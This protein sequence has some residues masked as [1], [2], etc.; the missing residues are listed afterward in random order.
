MY[1]NGIS[2]VSGN[3]GTSASD[4]AQPLYIGSY[5][6]G[7]LD[8]LNG[9]LSN[10]RI[11]KGTAVYTSNFTPP[12]A[13]LT[14]ITN[15]SLLTCQSNR[16]VDNSTNNFA[17][18]RNGDVRVTP[19]SPF[20]PS[21]AYSPSVNG[22]SGYFDGSGDS[23]QLAS[24]INL[25]L[26]GD[27]T[28]ELWFY[29][30]SSANGRKFINRWSGGAQYYMI[31]A[32]ASNQIVF[33]FNTGSISITSSTAFTLNQWQHVAVS[34][35]GST[36][37]MYLNGISVG[38][39]TESGNNGSTSEPLFIGSYSNNAE[40]FHG[41]ISNV[42]IVKGTAVY[43][44]AFTPPTTPP[45]AITNTSLL[46]NFTNGG[47]TDAT[48]RNNLETMGNARLDTS[49]KK[50]GTS[51]ISL[52]NT[53]TGTSRL[54]AAHAPWLNFP[55]AFTFEA[56]VYP[57]NLSGTIHSILGK[58]GSWYWGV[59][60]GAYSGLVRLIGAG[61]SILA[62]SV[63]GAVVVNQWQHLAMT[64]DTSNNLR[65]FVN[66]T[67]SGSTNNSSDALTNVVNLSIGTYTPGESGYDWRGYID[68][69]RLTQ[70]IA[71]YTA[72]FTPPT[73]P[74]PQN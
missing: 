47:I 5:G 16:F 9:Y 25:A 65:I 8:Y 30:L 7:P 69:L 52:P 50:Y 38:T 57:T 31:E 35:S 53:T 64:R 29:A 72:N 60:G 73:A 58:Y 6:A 27:F 49:I 13:P 59:Y 66:G 40:N 61:G 43:T 67:Q 45:T 17:I 48:G 63:T 36:I 19:F 12:T 15:T 55:G 39:R 26:S 68:D 18:T 46:L 42:R 14:A 51:S 2:V 54:I 74:F 34:R 33:L 10:F 71:H 44:S 24:N 22:G 21:A 3:N 1:I 32:N 56:W 23:I 28:I 41:Y 70:G 20:A 37:T 62:S 11:V 4:L